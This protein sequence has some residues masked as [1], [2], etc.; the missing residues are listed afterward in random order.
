MCIKIEDVESKVRQVWEDEILP[1]IFDII[2]EK[3]KTFLPTAIAK[4]IME[5]GK[6]M[7]MSPKTQEEFKNVYAILDEFRDTLSKNSEFHE[8]MRPILFAIKTDLEEKKALSNLS[9]KVIF[10][11]KV[12]G[13]VAVII[14]G[15]V[16]GVRFLLK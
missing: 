1:K 10:V 13:A 14:G 4:G 2:D 3:N 15:L 8:E 9:E 7:E 11:S 5:A 12:I 6:H 16:A